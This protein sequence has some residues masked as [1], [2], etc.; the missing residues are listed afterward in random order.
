MTEIAFQLIH[1]PDGK[2]KLRKGET[3]HGVFESVALGEEAIQRILNPTVRNYNSYG[4][5]IK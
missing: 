5:L 3:D 1:R 4:E 2:W